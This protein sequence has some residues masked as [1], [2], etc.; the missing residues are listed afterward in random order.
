MKKILAAFFSLAAISFA[1]NVQVLAPSGAEFA[2]DAPNMVQSIVRASVSETGNTPVESSAEIQLRTSVMTMGS[3]FV[4]VCEQINNGTIVGSGRQK[5]NSIDNLDYAIDWAV[6]GAL[7]NLAGANANM[8]GAPQNANMQ[9][10]PQN[11]N[12]ANNGYYQEPQPNVVVV[13]PAERYEQRNGDPNDNFAHKR[14]TRNY[15]SYGLGAALWHN[16]DFTEKDCKGDVVC[17]EK[18]D[19]DRTWEQAFVF[20]YARIFEVIPQAAV[21]IVNNMN[22]SFGD[23]WEWHETFLLGGRFFPS[24]GVVTP[25]IGAGIGLGIQTDSHY[26]DGDE[27]FAI[28]LAGGAELGIIFFRNSATQLEIGFAWDALWDGFESFDRRFGAGSAYIA[29]NY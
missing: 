4:V 17:H 23:E 1:A 7:A 5:A 16:Y 11:G 26:Y 28:G 15:V 21:T 9:G 12:Y 10:A 6:K 22:I 19:T 18:Y 8:Q 20:H 14:P 27:A 3:S 13:V 25:F 24:T 29:I 2:P